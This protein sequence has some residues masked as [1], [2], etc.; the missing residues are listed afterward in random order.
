[1]KKIKFLLENLLVEKLLFLEH[2]FHWSKKKRMKLDFLDE[3][4]STIE[5][6]DVITTIPKEIPTSFFSLPPNLNVNNIF[7]KIKDDGFQNQMKQI[8][9][10]KGTTTLGF[11]FNKG[12]VIAVDSRASMGKYICKFFFFKTKSASQSVKKVI[13]INPFLL[14]TMAGGAADC[15]FWE[16][17]LGME[18]RLYELRNKKRISIAAASKIL[19]NIM[20]N[21]KG[22]GLS[23]GTMIA[24]WDHSGPNLFMVDNDGTR[25]KGDFFS[26]GSGSMYAYGIIDAGRDPDM[27]EEDA[28]ALGRRAIYHATHRDAYSGG[29]VRVYLIRSDGWIK[30]SETDATEL[31]YQYEEEKLNSLKK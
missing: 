30:I 3:D 13:E 27:S 16:R 8:K 15:Q 1:L 31:H 2:N 7:I 9:F 19:A 22:M 23:M 28:C 10:N 18:C 26:V 14:G 12:V 5:K 24:G 17:Y 4:Y 6:T 29:T 20:Y 25:L 21:Y 11:K